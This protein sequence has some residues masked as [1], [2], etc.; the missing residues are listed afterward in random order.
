MLY[1]YEIEFSLL[2]LPSS[3]KNASDA[4]SKRKDPKELASQRGGR[5][6]RGGMAVKAPSRA[7]GRSFQSMQQTV[8][9]ILIHS[10]H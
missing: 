2:T 8:S 3:Y 9:P 10:V 4:L 5:G 7:P 1:V 6:G